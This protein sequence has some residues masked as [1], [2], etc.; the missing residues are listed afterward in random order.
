MI[1]V[2]QSTTTWLPQTQTWMHN[3]TKYLPK[4][5]ESH[6]VCSATENLDQF[7]MPHLHGIP[8]ESLLYRFSRSGMK[9]AKPTAH[10]IWLWRKCLRLKPDIVHSHFGKTGWYDSLV[11][12]WTH[13]RHVVTFYGVDVSMVPVQHKQWRTR[14]TSLF[15]TADLFLCEG[16]HMAKC[17]INLGCPPEKVKLHHLGVK[18]DKISY[19]P[20][21]WKS[22][23]P[24]R[25][26]IAGSFR[27]KKGIPYALE[28]LGLLQHTVR[29]EITVIGDATREQRSIEE[30]KK[31][32]NVIEKHGLS[33]KT[34]L[35]GFQPYSIL[36]KEA[37]EHHIFISPSVTSDDGDTEGGAPVTIIEMIASGM[38]VV[39]TTHCDIPGVINYEI[40]KWLVPERDIE[41]L[42]DRVNWLLQNIS[43]W[44]TIL[45]IG[46]NF[47]E[48]NFNTAHQGHRLALHYKN[49]TETG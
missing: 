40:D 14:Y 48:Q 18:V 26:L 11:V 32:L 44:N 20:R 1:T 4:K 30:K 29:L 13:A 7:P 28:A 16:P 10:L 19:R 9:R 6:I 12:R 38:P 41:G 3:Q 36:L 25:I 24:L 31:I 33:S 47:I 34:R 22:E 42:V 8:E 49:V 15:K 45:A 2:I 39:S 43:Q 35:M 23:D 21:Q 17:L 27:E 37:Y 5:I 46:R